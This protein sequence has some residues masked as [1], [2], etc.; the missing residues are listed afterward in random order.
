MNTPLRRIS[1]FVALL[2]AA[3][4]VSSTVIQFVQAPSIDARPGNTRTTLDSYSR[5]RGSI[6]VGDTPIAR[7]VATPRDQIAYQ[8]TY[9][10]A[11]LY[12]QVTG[13]FSVVYGAGGGLEGSADDLLAG[14]A[15]QLFYRRVTDVLTGR[16]VSGASLR[17]TI[18]AKAQEAADQALGDQRGA[19]VALDPR[20]GAILAMVS[21]PQY[22]P[23]QL[24]SHDGGTQQ[25]AWTQDN[26]AASYQP[27]VNRA[28]GGNLYP[29]G[30]VFKIVTAA[31]ALENGVVTPQTQIP[32]PARLDLP[33]TSVG[34]PNE[35]GQ[36]CGANDR[37]TL[38]HALEISCNTAMGY[39]GMQLGADRLG[40]EAEKFGFG[41]TLRVPTRVSPSAFPTDLDQAQTARAAI[42]QESVRVTPLQ[43]AMVAAAV[44]NKGVVMKPY[45]VQDVLASDLSTIDEAQ[46]EQLGQAMSEQTAATLTQMLIGVVQQGT[47][48]P[49]QI[50]GVQVAG[51]TG[52]AEQGN[53]KPP[54]AW[55]TAFAP[56]NDPKVAVA[57]V[58]ED[59]G[60]AGSEAAGGR[61]AGPV[62]KAVIEAVLNR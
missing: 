19:V 29:P 21:H 54:H 62:A 53:G 46:P 39:L 7:S 13:Y 26:S 12:S 31:A 6:I 40:A 55:F 23:N 35:N 51:K 5:D 60:N 1:R 47:G 61:N 20:T 14:T 24:A 41:Q 45:L 43:V 57:V 9:P 36:A 59:G 34:L 10:D 30:S 15:D 33:Q 25:K 38:Q 18:D 22:D 3:L 52:T 8:R 28:I 32:A 42:G 17:L 56:A 2:F 44:A 49:A 4:L 48:T 50:P 16:Q 58:V 27:I 11:K 37:T